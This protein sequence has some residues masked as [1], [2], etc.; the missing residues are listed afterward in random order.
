MSWTYLPRRLDLVN[1][2]PH[3]V[4]F[5]HQAELTSACHL[6]LISQSRPYTLNC[7]ILWGGWHRL[8]GRLQAVLAAGAQVAA[9]PNLCCDGDNCELWSRRFFSHISLSCQ[10]RVEFAIDRSRTACAC[11]VDFV[12]QPA[13]LWF[14]PRY[15]AAAVS[16]PGGWASMADAKA[17]S[18]KMFLMSRRKRRLHG[19]FIKMANT[20]YF[21]THGAS[22]F[23][24]CAM[25][26]VILG[27]L[28]CRWVQLLH[29]LYCHCLPRSQ[30]LPPVQ[31]LA[32]A[33]P[34]VRTC[35]QY[36]QHHAIEVEPGQAGW[37][38]F[39]ERGTFKDK[40]EPIGTTPDS[41]AGTAVDC[42]ISWK[43]LSL[44]F[45]ALNIFV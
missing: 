28:I 42:V 22:A 10:F 29:R 23:K 8:G 7:F 11:S 27:S 20:W 13:L 38:K 5:W 16:D 34:S 33:S 31:H 1:S 4:W 25:L 26:S 17:A 6:H 43:P 24:M 36:L 41:L 37:R 18:L 9:P 12:E 39:R 30:L 3:L 14:A 19:Q 44:T 15:P 45:L 35:L 40:G 32:Q 2:E 21:L